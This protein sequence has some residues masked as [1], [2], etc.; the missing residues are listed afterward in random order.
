MQA[1]PSH[2]WRSFLATDRSGY[3]EK[4]EVH[5]CSFEATMLC[6]EIDP[7]QV[8]AEWE[9]NMARADEPVEVDWFELN[10]GAAGA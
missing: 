8:A 5:V 4:C 6:R 3:C 9:A 10:K 1:H 7:V 2:A